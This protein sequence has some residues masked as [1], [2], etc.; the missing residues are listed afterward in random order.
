MRINKAC[1]LLKYFGYQGASLKKT[2]VVAKLLLIITK[3]QVFDYG[4]QFM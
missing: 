1:Q 3:S 2:G 4:K